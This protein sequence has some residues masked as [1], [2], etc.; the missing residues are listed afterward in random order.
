MPPTRIE[1]RRMAWMRRRGYGI[2]MENAESRLI[3][4]ASMG[5]GKCSVRIWGVRAEVQEAYR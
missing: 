2:G 4:F 1:G 3:V 5:L